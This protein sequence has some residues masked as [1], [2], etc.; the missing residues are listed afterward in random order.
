M[1]K[2]VTDSQNVVPARAEELG[3]RFAHPELDEA[4]A[5]ALSH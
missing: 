3:M 4:L 2:I 1:A 5:D